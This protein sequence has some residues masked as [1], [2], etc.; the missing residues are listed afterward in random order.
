[1]RLTSPS[2]ASRTRLRTMATT[3]TSMRKAAVV[4][5]AARLPIPIV[6]S[7]GSL[8]VPFDPRRRMK[9]A[10]TSVRKA[11]PAAGEKFTV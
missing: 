9:S 6:R 2:V 5:T 7:E 3:I 10:K 4:I 11:S 8:D 1:M